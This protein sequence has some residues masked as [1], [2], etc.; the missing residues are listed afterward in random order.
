MIKHIITTNENGDIV[1]ECNQTVSPSQN[2][3]ANNPDEA[4]CKNCIRIN[5]KLKEKS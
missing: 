1:Y 3:I 5:N 2:K 4:T